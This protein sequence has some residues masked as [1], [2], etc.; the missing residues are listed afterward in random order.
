[1]PSQQVSW[2]L[3]LFVF[4]QSLPLLVFSA[5]SIVLLSLSSLLLFSSLSFLFFPLLSLF[6]FS[7]PALL[8][9]FLSLF[10]FFSFS[11]TLS[12]I[13]GG[14]SLVETEQTLDTVDEAAEM[15]GSTQT[16]RVG[17]GRV[18]GE[19]VDIGVAQAIVFVVGLDLVVSHGWI[20]G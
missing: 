13:K 5:L 16:V 10:L 2:P 6:L 11:S 18:G 19:D 20:D 4:F 9:L 14:D 17:R 12:L 15:L 8:V 3:S 1:M 7:N